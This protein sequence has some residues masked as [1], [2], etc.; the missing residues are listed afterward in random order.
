MWARSPCLLA[1][2]I[3]TR[4]TITP[5]ATAPESQL[6]PKDAHVPTLASLLKQCDSLSVGR[7]A[8]DFITKEPS[9]VQGQDIHIAIVKYGYEKDRLLGTALL[10]LYGECGF[11]PD[12]LKVFRSISGLDTASWN[13]MIVSV[14]H[15]GAL[16]RAWT[17]ML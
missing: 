17:C 10:S 3:H 1:R 7:Q 4:N 14:I 6:N 13:A 5:L 12:A 2:Y 16:M 9:L 11:L 8:H 15:S